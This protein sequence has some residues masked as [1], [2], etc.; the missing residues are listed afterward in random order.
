MFKCIFNY[1]EDMEVTVFYILQAAIMNSLSNTFLMFP[2]L[3]VCYNLKMDR[4]NY[5]INLA[6]IV[7]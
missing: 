6:P 4:R 5:R 3:I 2:N 1:G 7:A